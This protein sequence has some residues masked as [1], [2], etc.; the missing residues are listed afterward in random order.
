MKK[1]SIGIIVV[2]VIVVFAEILYFLNPMS[3]PKNTTTTE[4]I[5]QKVLSVSP[6]ILQK[7]TDEVAH[8]T[9]SPAIRADQID[10]LRR[11][12]DTGHVQTTL[13]QEFLGNIF[14]IQRMKYETEKGQ[15]TGYNIVLTTDGITDEYKMNIFAIT[16]NQQ[17]VVKVYEKKM[18]KLEPINLTDLKEG[19]TVQIV[20]EADL[21]KSFGENIVLETI[22]RL[23]K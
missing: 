11:S 5:A 15:V 3:R 9:Y 2:L 18:E 23:E 21:S 4:P 22:T 16:D 7:R 12:R 10:W 17:S 6:T 14:K 19:D 13:R 1:I 20:T 8:T